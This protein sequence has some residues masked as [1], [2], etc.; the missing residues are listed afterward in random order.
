MAGTFDFSRDALARAQFIHVRD[1]AGQVPDSL[2]LRAAVGGYGSEIAGEG[3]AR[4]TAEAAEYAGRSVEL[5][6]A[7]STMHAAAGVFREGLRHVP[8]YVRAG[9]G[10][11]QPPGDPKSAGL[12]SAAG[13][14]AGRSAAWLAMRDVFDSTPGMIWWPTFRAYLPVFTF[15]VEDIRALSPLDQAW[16]LVRASV[17]NLFSDLAQATP[18]PLEVEQTTLWPGVHGSSAPC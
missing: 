15:V 9:P 6:A 13:P 11:E 17:Q 8:P 5:Q 7:G 1:H 10:S 4:F 14:R 18:A 16:A 3:M 2:V 12:G